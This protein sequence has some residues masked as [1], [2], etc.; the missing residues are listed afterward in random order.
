MN[1]GIERIRL[2][3]VSNSKLKAF[4]DLN[5]DD[6]IIITGFKVMDGSS[7]LFLCNPSEL[8]RKDDKY[9]DTVYFTTRAHKEDIEKIVLDRYR[10]ELSN[11]QESGYLDKDTISLTKDESTPQLGEATKP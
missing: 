6:T 8:G 1:V 2:S 7:G 4:V 10:L 5:I 11:I 3:K 9:Y